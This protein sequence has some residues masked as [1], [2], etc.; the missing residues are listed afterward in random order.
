MATSTPGSR[1]DGRPVAGDGETI[2]SSSLAAHGR[3]PR[4]TAAHTEAARFLGECIG[5]GAVLGMVAAASR[6]RRDERRAG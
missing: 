1:V 3:P 4:W 2:E 5:G 6:S